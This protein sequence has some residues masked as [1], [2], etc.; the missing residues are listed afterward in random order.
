MAKQYMIESQTKQLLRRKQRH[1]C[2]FRRAV[3]FPL[4]AFYARGD[5]I[6]RRAFAALCPRQDVVERKVLGVTMLAAILAAVTVANV[7]T[8]PLHRRLRTIAADVNVMAKP[9]H[10][11]HREN[12]RGRAQNIVAVVFLDINRAAK[13]K[14]DSTS[15][16]NSAKR[17]V[18]KVQ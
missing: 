7:N 6:G 18:R 4:I 8:C 11:R 5:Q 15:D 12:G 17:L 13:P 16:T 9:D 14:A 1:P 3:A 10:G 2:L